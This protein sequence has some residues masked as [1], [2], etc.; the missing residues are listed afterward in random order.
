MKYFLALPLSSLVRREL[1]RIC[2]PLHGKAHDIRWSSPSRYHITLRYFGVLE[3]AG[4]HELLRRID[5]QMCTF[6]TVQLS[7]RGLGVFGTE[8]P[9]VLFAKVHGE[10]SP[11]EDW[12]CRLNA[13]L[14]ERF[15]ASW[16][17]ATPAWVP[18]VTVAR[19]RQRQGAPDLQQIAETTKCEIQAQRVDEV[20]FL[21]SGQARNQTDYTL[22]RKFALRAPHMRDTRLDKTSQGRQVSDPFL[23]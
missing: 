14:R 7:F 6:P 2:L 5:Q 12:L 21:A 1:A 3:P 11:L 23:E 19:A 13:D 22:I 20:H 10:L 16:L 4:L 15:G 18:H 9:R 8:K 17:A